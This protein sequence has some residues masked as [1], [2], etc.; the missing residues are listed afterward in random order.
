MVR[1]GVFSKDCRQIQSR[2]WVDLYCS[3]WSSNCLQKCYY[4]ACYS[5][6][7]QWKSSYGFGWNCCCSRALFFYFDSFEKS[8]FKDFEALLWL[9]IWVCESVQWEHWRCSANQNIWR[10]PWACEE[11][12]E[13]ILEFG[14]L[15]IGLKLYLLRTKRHLRPGQYFHHSLCFVIRYFSQN[16]QK[17]RH[18]HPSYEYPFASEPGRCAQK[19]FRCRY[20][21]INLLQD[22][23]RNVVFI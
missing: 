15:Q 23:Y 19:H 14:F 10:W 6:V 8:T 16:E 11:G 12:K 2:L 5:S 7:Y 13:E 1:W 20:Q 17:I 3:S 22:Q 21:R 4:F 9:Q 18:C